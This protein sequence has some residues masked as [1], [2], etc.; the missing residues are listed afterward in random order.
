MTTVK[1]QHD[2]AKLLDAV[3]GGS[4]DALGEVYGRYAGVV[5]G[6]ALQMT[7]SCD[8]A[9]D[10]LQD[11]FVGL[12]RALR[13]YEE[14]GR[15]ESWLR[16]VTART[17]L[18]RLRAMRRKRE[19]PLEEATVDV[20]RRACTRSIALP[21]S[22]RSRACPSDCASSSCYARSRDTATRRSP[23]CWGSRAGVPRPGSRE[24]GRCCERTSTYE[25]LSSFVR[26]GPNLVD[27]ELPAGK[28]SRVA[29]HLAACARC[30]S[31]SRPDRAGAQDRAGRAWLERRPPAH[32]A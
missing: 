9:E 1:R 30:R 25:D 15:F 16:R 27:G 17:A 5:Y 23:R 28:R 4:L 31:A 26:D 12:S 2:E 24:P 8:E 18:M 19:A 3:R 29:A 11:V 21:F 22:A 32:G 14:R 20:R 10:V 6:L 13:S 7:G